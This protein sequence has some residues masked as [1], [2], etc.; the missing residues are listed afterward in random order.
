[1]AQTP[2]SVE[3]VYMDPHLFRTS[4]GKRAIYSGT[5]VP[6]VCSNLIYQS[7]EVTLSERI[8]EVETWLSSA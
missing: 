5:T 8:M 6:S 3:V 7:P 4:W 2:T 1:M